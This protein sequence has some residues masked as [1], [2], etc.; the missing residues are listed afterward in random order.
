MKC[1]I[2]SFVADFVHVVAWL[3]D[4][5][6]ITAEESAN[7]DPGSVQRLSVCPLP[8]FLINRYSG[9]KMCSQWYVKR[10]SPE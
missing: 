6:T 7:S 1:L 2:P 8:P 10:T 3:S 9:P 4:N 5:D